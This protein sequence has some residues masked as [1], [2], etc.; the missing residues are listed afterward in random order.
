MSLAVLISLPSFRKRRMWLL[1]TATRRSQMS[2]PA[3]G[4]LKVVAR[5]LDTSAVNDA[6][7]RKQKITAVVTTGVVWSQ[8]HLAEIW[9]PSLQCCQR[10]FDYRRHRKPV[11]SAL[12]KYMDVGSCLKR[13]LEWLNKKK[14]QKF[15]P[16][17]LTHFL[18]LASGQLVVQTRI[19]SPFH[20]FALV[21]SVCKKN[22]HWIFLQILLK[23][24]ML[25][26]KKEWL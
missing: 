20:I 6:G 7:E 15:N 1:R 11:L 18:V 26:W 19:N 10:V 4:S 25:T 9:L 5:D 12:V 14:N 8:V 2:L 17:S 13:I 23:S 16:E 21:Q 22:L 24:Y 3:C